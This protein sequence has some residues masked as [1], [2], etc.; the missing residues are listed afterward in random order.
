MD[1]LK[2]MEE[3]KDQRSFDRL[4][5]PEISVLLI[6]SNWYYLLRYKFFRRIALFIL[7]KSQL[8]DL[9]TSGSCILTHSNFKPGDLIRM[10]IYIQG[11]KNIFIKGTVRWISPGTENNTYYAGIRFV[12]YGN[13]KRYNSYKALDQ[14][15]LYSTQNA[16]ILAD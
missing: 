10:I 14:L 8:Q 13:R 15:R 7:R 1:G 9:S 4:N 16:V 12:A 5:T 2:K 3:I 6:N 11:Q